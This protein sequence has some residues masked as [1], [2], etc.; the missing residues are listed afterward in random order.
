MVAELK[1]NVILRANP[2]C[3]FLE[4]SI[5]DSAHAAH[6]PNYP[7]TPDVWAGF[8]VVHQIGNGGRELALRDFDDRIFVV[9]Q[10]HAE[11]VLG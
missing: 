8:Y 10:D 4:I 11:I 5:W 6:N 7:Q 9:H 3:K 2:G 1:Q